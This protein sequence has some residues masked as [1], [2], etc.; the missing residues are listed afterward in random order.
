MI[1]RC[2]ALGTAA[3]LSLFA[4]DSSAQTSLAAAPD[5][6]VVDVQGGQI[7]VVTIATGLVHPWSV[8]FLP[9]RTLLVAEAGRVRIIRGDALDPLPAFTMP[10]GTSKENND[11]LKWLAVHPRFAANRLVYLSYPLSGERGTTL[12]VGRARFDGKTL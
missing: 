11:T 7:R 1:R 5:S 8:A 9:D 6:Q 4:V 12:A 3:L 10:A 2:A